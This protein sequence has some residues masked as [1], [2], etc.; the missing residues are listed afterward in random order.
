MNM[1]DSEES[2]LA[3]VERTIRRWLHTPDME[4]FDEGDWVLF[5]D[6]ELI[7][8]ERDR[9][10]EALAHLARRHGWTVDEL[11]KD[12]LGYDA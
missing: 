12:L 5:Y 1:C 3:P 2:R 8:D 11:V 4:P 10:R 6:V 7:L 9:Y